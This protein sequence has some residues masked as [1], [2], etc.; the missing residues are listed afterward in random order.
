MWYRSETAGDFGPLN[1]KFLYERDYKFYE[2]GDFKRFLDNSIM[3]SGTSREIGIDQRAFGKPKLIDKAD[4]YNMLYSLLPIKSE[5]D[6]PVNWNS[7]A[8]SITATIPE[9]SRAIDVS[10][11]SVIETGNYIVDN[12]SADARIQGTNAFKHRS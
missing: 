4:Q 11:Q 10:D 7:V 8:K 2:I 9:G 3:D 1:Y 12:S 6:P 5:Y